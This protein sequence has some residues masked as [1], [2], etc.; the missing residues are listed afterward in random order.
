M[1]GVG[2]GGRGH[3]WVGI[4]QKRQLAQSELIPFTKHEMWK[5]KNNVD[6]FALSSPRAGD[7]VAV[8]ESEMVTVKSKN[9]HDCGWMEWREANNPLEFGGLAFVLCF[10]PILFQ[11]SC[12]ANVMEICTKDFRINSADGQWL[13]VNGSKTG[14]NQIEGTQGRRH[15]SLV[16]GR[17]CD[18]H[19]YAELSN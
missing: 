14:V 15:M 7:D 3:C 18:W 13:K 11:E 5:L 4:W 10:H 2:E 16:L 17:A 6:V 19:S 8:V 12:V 1:W 9:V